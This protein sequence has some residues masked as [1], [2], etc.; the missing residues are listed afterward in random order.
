MELFV[1][2]FQSNRCRLPR[3]IHESLVDQLDNQSP[4]VVEK[5]PRS[6]RQ[7]HFEQE[8]DTADLGTHSA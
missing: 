4:L 8:P 6:L 7:D 1:T 5:L 2:L 3:E